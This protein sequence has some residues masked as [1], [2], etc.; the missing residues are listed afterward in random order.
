MADEVKTLDKQLPIKAITICPAPIF[1]VN[2]TDSVIG[3]TWILTVSI[4]T[5]KGFKNLGAPIGSNPA[6]TDLKLKKMADIMREA[7]KGRPRESEMARCLVV[8]KT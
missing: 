1:A 5:K 8:L 2:R 3:R 6:T 4:K 7:H